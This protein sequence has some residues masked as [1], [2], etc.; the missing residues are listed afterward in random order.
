MFI[1]ERLLPSQLI[2]SR[3]GFLQQM[4]DEEVVALVFAE[5]FAHCVACA[6][7]KDELEVLASTLKGIDNLVRRR[8]V[9]VVVHFAYYEHEL[10]F[11]ILCVL[12]V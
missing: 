4:F 1:K 12:N 7:E 9:Y 10:A 2:P 11:Q 3:R 5:T 6:R 8:R